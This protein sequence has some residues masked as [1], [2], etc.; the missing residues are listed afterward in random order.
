MDM[1]KKRGTTEVN[2]LV[3][4]DMR[5][6]SVACLRQGEV[7]MAARCMSRETSAIHFDAVIR[8]VRG[9]ARQSRLYCISVTI[10]E[11]MHDPVSD[12]A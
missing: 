1:L 7:R 9:I 12:S 8:I 3:S 2:G 6:G 5:M 4:S 10:C 11:R